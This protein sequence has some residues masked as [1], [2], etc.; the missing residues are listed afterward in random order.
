M[1]TIELIGMIRKTLWTAVAFAVVVLGL[2][3]NMAIA[4]DGS[5]KVYFK[6]NKTCLVY[7]N[8]QIPGS[9]VF[10]NPNDYTTL[11]ALTVPDGSYMVSSKLSAFAA[12]GTTYVN[13]ECA[14]LDESN[15]SA[16][17]MSSF[18][19][20]AEQTLFLQAP[21]SFSTGSGGIIRI[22]CRA[23]GFQL[24]GTLVD[25]HVW[26][27]NIAATKVRSVIFE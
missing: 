1:K 7:P 4:D 9:P 10:P 22:G 25:M 16:L 12:N 26:N 27:V 24:N 18:D 23:F 3:S 21:I 14:L 20:T 17:D 15:N 6:E 19:G 8:C 2:S 5:S 11:A 13:F